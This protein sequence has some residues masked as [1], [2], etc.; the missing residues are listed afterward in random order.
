MP[1]PKKKYDTQD[2]ESIQKE[3]QEIE[4]RLLELKLSE[5]EIDYNSI[6]SVIEEEKYVQAYQSSYN[7]LAHSWSIFEGRDFVGNKGAQAIGEHL[8]ACLAGQIKRLIINVA[9]RCLVKGSEV[10]MSDNSYKKIEEVEIGDSV[11]SYD[12]KIVHEKV[13]DVISSGTKS[14]LELKFNDGNI[15]RCS[16]NH[17]IYTPHGW[18]E[19]KDLKIH[20][21]VLSCKDKEYADEILNR[22]I[23]YLEIQE[24]KEIGEQDC[25]DLTIN[26]T[27][28][29]FCDEILV[30]NSGKSALVNK[31]FPAFAWI[32]KPEL[33]IANCSYSGDLAYDGTI[34]SKKIITSDWYRKG[35]NT[36]WKDLNGSDTVWDISK[37]NRDLNK[38][39]YN[40]ANGRRFCTSVGGTFTGKGADFILIDDPLSP[41]EAESKIERENCIR[42]ARKTLSSRLDDKVNGVMILIM[43]RLN[44]CLLPNSLIT[45]PVGVVEI[46]NLKMGDPVISSQ[47]KD[48]V[49]YTSNKAYNGLIYGIKTY[50]HY[51]TLWVTGTHEILTERGWIEAKDLLQKDILV[52]KI[53]YKEKI[54]LTHVINLY[55]EI[56]K[57]NSYKK[58]TGNYKNS[59]PSMEK[60]DLKKQLTH[61]KSIV[62]VAKYFKL[63]RNTIQNYMYYYGLSVQKRNEIPKEILE[64]KMFWRFIGY[65]LAEG[66]VS[67]SKGKDAIITLVFNKSETEYINDIVNLFNSYV[68]VKITESTINNSTRVCFSSTQLSKFLTDNFGR[69]SHGKFIPEWC[70]KLSDEFIKEILLGYYRGDGSYSN[71]YCRFTSVSINLLTGI[72]HLLY[73]LGIKSNLIKNPIRQ[74][75]G[76]FLN[77][78][79]SY[80]LRTYLKD[81]IWLEDNN[82]E[83]NSI[84]DTTKEKNSLTKIKIKSIEIKEYKGD[85]YDITTNAGNFISGLITV[86]NCDLAQYYID[87]EDW[88]LLKIPTEWDES[89][90]FWTSLGWTDWRKV[91][92]ESADPVRFPYE[93]IEEEKKKPDVWSSQYQQEPVPEGGGKIKSSWWNTYWVLP[94]YFDSICMAFDLNTKKGDNNDN[95]ALVVV[96]R[97]DDSFYVIDLVYANMDI[98]DQL[99]AIVALDD[100]YPYIHK[101]LIEDKSNGSAVW[102]L[103]NK[104]VRG[105]EP[106]DPKGIDK[107]LRITASL[108]PKLIKQS[109]YLPPVDTHPWVKYI[110]EESKFFPRGK[111][112]DA[113][114]HPDTLIPVLKQSEDFKNYKLEKIVNIEIGDKVFTHNGNW[115]NVT[116]LMNRDFDGEILNVKTCGA[117]SI[118]I[119]DNHNVPCYL[120]QN[121]KNRNGKRLINRLPMGKLNK[122]DMLFEVRHNIEQQIED[123][124][125]LNFQEFPLIKDRKINRHNELI[126]TEEY[127]KF[128]NCKSNPINR[129]IKV[130]KELCRLI[131]YYIAEGSCGRHNV[132]WAFNSNE[133]DYQLDVE[134]LIEHCFGLKTARTKVRKNCGRVG[135]SNYFL[136]AFFDQFGDRA[137]NKFLPMWLFNLPKELLAELVKGYWYG[138]G[139]RTKKNNYVLTTSSSNLYSAFKNILYKFGIT[140]T[141]SIS[142]KNG[143]YKVIAGNPMSYCHPLFNMCFAGS[144]A[145]LFAQLVG[146]F[147]TETQTIIESKVINK[148]EKIIKSI[149]NINKVQYTGKVY[150]L[151]VEDDHSYHTESFCVMNCDALSYAVNYLDNNTHI[152]RMPIEVYTETKE[153]Y[154]SRADARAV[155]DDYSSYDIPIARS[156]KYIKGL[157]N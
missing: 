104:T 153:N 148:E 20:N 78:R 1:F 7:F 79:I 41:E 132:E 112:D 22:D 54:N 48:E 55:P 97:K 131:G 103:L 49:L 152:V 25:F 126:V 80:E 34:D 77:N 96:G 117:K 84:V 150:N 6:E 115:K 53:D 140:S 52:Y 139:C 156:N 92:G 109:I 143:V 99:A 8:D 63:H 149:W 128:T 64:N 107:E 27:E 110:L 11:Y 67:K 29:F 123:I 71:N 90:R 76:T 87:N 45:T 65:W 94:T 70:D 144:N 147:Y 44:M 138:D 145:N 59:K 157:F 3:L 122:R 125:M 18:I 42:W 31:A 151:E 43:Q 114:L 57:G 95:T 127:I 154:I 61:C 85:V 141:I 58:T 129:Y 68:S 155:F 24:I 98:T 83:L 16:I 19:A 142:R 134:R 10:L 28:C 118:L 26:N 74:Y 146:D 37:T 121:N 56:E 100:K 82:I 46:Q 89:K 116:N 120:R 38:D 23:T 88:E 51:D 32:K 135:I 86:H 75:P 101:K 35:L 12:N 13:T 36:V 124:D 111:H 66:C 40:T 62:D 2:R 17:R 93:F 81:S 137:I 113:C 73:R 69:L 39:Y 47:G 60:E 130:D 91:N 5:A 14:C 72:R 108:V 21:I 133:I 9:P 33:R 136:R 30:H 50:G 119:T 102:T 106:V 105:L 4:R 15:L